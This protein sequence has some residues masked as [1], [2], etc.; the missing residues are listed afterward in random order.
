MRILQISSAVDFGGGEKHIVDLGRSLKTRGHEVF[1]A[2]RPTNTLIC[3]ARG[4]LSTEDNIATPCS[5]KA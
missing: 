4:L 2:L 1:F 3:T 5:V